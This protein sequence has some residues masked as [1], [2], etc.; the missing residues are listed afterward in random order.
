MKKDDS[1]YINKFKNDRSKAFIVIALINICVLGIFLSIGYY[2][3]LTYNTKPYGII[4]TIV[5]SFPVGQFL[6]YKSLKRKFAK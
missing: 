4:A 1:Y 3:D 5:V 2:F 6:I